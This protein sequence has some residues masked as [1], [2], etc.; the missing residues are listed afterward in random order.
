MLVISFSKSD[1]DGFSVYKTVS[2]GVVGGTGIE[3]I[4]KCSVAIPVFEHH[5]MWSPRQQQSKSNQLLAITPKRDT[6]TL[7]IFQKGN[8]FWSIV[9]TIT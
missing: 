2:Q 3:V 7:I 1:V 5:Q 4:S 6:N 9:L 8:G